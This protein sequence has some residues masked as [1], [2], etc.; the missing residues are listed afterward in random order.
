MRMQPEN[1]IG[2]AVRRAFGFFDPKEPAD[3]RPHRRTDHLLKMNLIPLMGRRDAAFDR[4]AELMRAELFTLSGGERQAIYLETKKLLRRVERD[5][6]KIISI[7]SSPD[8]ERRERGFLDF[9]KLLD[10][11]ADALESFVAFENRLSLN[12]EETHDFSPLRDD[13]EYA[14]SEESMTATEITLVNQL[15]AFFDRVARRVT[16]YREYVTKSLSRSYAERYAS[17]H[18]F[19]L[20]SLRGETVSQTPSTL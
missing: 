1:T 11:G 9:V 13:S 7:L 20:Q 6:E 12:S 5:T 17:S 3:F 18:R 15:R 14:S 2:R 8:T 19:Y 4:V 16:R 10:A